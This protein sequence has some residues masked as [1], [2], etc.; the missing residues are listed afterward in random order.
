MGEWVRYLL[1]KGQQWSAAVGLDL[2]LELAHGQAEQN[3][4][5][6][7]YGSTEGWAQQ[8][9]SKKFKKCEQPT[10]QLN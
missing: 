9:V 3:G 7:L 8:I 4:Q 10:S 5:T 2:D 1:A 6:Q